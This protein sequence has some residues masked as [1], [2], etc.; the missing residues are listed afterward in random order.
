MTLLR[1]IRPI[2]QEELDAYVPGFPFCV[3]YRIRK[4]YLIVIAVYHQS[5]DPSGWKG[6]P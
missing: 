2:A 1:K 4:P 5:R 6:R 3:Y